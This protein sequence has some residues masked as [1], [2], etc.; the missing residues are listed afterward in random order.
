V[1]VDAFPD[2]ATRRVTGLATRRVTGLATRRV[3]RPGDESRDR[4][5][6]ESRDRP[7]DESRDRPGARRRSCP[8]ALFAPLCFEAF[9]STQF[10]ALNRTLSLSG[11]I[12]NPVAPP[13]NIRA[14]PT[15]FPAVQGTYKVVHDVDASAVDAK[16]MGKRGR[17]VCI[18]SAQLGCSLFP[19]TLFT[20]SSL[21][22]VRTNLVAC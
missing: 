6:D 9:V 19:N 14:S 18:Q 7:R 1:G 3:I 8:T 17:W 5:R 16:R 4:P 22:S 13:C 10:V 11:P 15:I 21:E 12:S 20:S 2:L